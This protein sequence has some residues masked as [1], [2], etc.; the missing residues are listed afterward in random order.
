[1]RNPTSKT[2]TS[3]EKDIQHRSLA[4][5]CTC[6]HTQAHAHRKRQTDRDKEETQRQTKYKVSFFFK[7]NLISK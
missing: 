7:I 4:S 3:I 2:K 6:T 5:I 1:M